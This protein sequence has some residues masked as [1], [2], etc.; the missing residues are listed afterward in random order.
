MWPIHQTPGDPDVPDDDDD[1]DLT[2]WHFNS[3]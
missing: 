2:H 1:Y 3:P